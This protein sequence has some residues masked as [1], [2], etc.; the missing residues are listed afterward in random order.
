[1]S[2]WQNGSVSTHKKH[3]KGAVVVPVAAAEGAPSQE[4]VIKTFLI[5]HSQSYRLLFKKTTQPRIVINFHFV[6]V[7]YCRFQSCACWAAACSMATVVILPSS[8]AYFRRRRL[9]FWNC[10]FVSTSC[11]EIHEKVKRR[12]LCFTKCILH[13]WYTLSLTWA[14]TAHC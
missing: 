14:P 1:M 2:G 4:R 6:E 5:G 13:Q 10:H 3:V 8:S 9:T 11:K 12:Y 7:S